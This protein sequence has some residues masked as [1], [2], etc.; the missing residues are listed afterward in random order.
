[1]A[2]SFFFD[3]LDIVEGFK[4][5]FESYERQIQRY[6]PNKGVDILVY[7]A[8]DEKMIR[9]SFSGK[10]GKIM[11]KKI[12]RLFHFTD[13]RSYVD[14][15]IDMS[16]IKVDNHKLSTVAKTLGVLTVEPKHNALNDSKTLF[17]VLAQILLKTE[18]FVV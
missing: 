4:Q 11:K 6:I 2:S 1:M 16:E 10:Q 15:F 7:G 9:A 3:N 18:E 17:N 8:N 14:D 5:I 13:C 12:D